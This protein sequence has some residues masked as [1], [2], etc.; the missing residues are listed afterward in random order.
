MKTLYFGFTVFIATTIPVIKILQYP[1]YYLGMRDLLRM[2]G[3]FWKQFSPSVFISVSLFVTYLIS[4][5]LAYL[6]IKK[7]NLKGRIPH[8]IAGAK[9]IWTGGVIMVLPSV[10]RILTSMVEGGGASFALMSIAVPF[11]LVAKVLLYI[12]SCNKAK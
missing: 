1:L 8:P 11:V 7:L 2:Y 6:L 9:L 12:A 3:P 10:L 5:G 4:F